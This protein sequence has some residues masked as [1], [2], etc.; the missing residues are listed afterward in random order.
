LP[1]REGARGYEIFD[2]KLDGCIK[3]LL[4]PAA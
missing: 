3:V 2:Q 4:D 1:L